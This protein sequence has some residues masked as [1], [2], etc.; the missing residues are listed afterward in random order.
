MSYG[1]TTLICGFPGIGKSWLAKRQS[2]FGINVLELSFDDIAFTK[3]LKFNTNFPA[4]YLKLIKENIGKYEYI[5]LPV[6]AEL[7]DILHEN[8]FIADII[9]PA[10]ELKDEYIIRYNNRDDANLFHNNAFNTK[11]ISDH[12]DE[13]ITRLENDTRHTRY[14][15]KAGQYLS[16]I[17]LNDYRN[18]YPHFVFQQD[19]TKKDIIVSTCAVCKRPIEG[20]GNYI[21]TNLVDVCINCVYKL[22]DCLGKP[23]SSE[24]C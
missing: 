8:N 16:D 24:E 17:G 5:F 6:S 11:F 20:Y 23:A 4:D 14:K 1:V 21:T 2:E 9:F 19:Y 13:T 15:L 18:L 22:K 7:L 3:D 10:I 12:W